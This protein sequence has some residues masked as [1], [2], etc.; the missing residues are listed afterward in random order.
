MVKEN[1]RGWFFP[2]IACSGVWEALDQGKRRF[3]MIAP[4]FGSSSSRAQESKVPISD[5]WCTK[6]KTD[7]P[8]RIDLVIS[9]VL[10]SVP[11]LIASKIP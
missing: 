1:G 4:V 3:E 5:F 10:Y 11:L 6:P 8:C 7:P 2:R 9:E